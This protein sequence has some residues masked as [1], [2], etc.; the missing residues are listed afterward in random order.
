MTAR[1]GPVRF[2]LVGCGSIAENSLVPALRTVEGGILWAVSSRD[3]EKARGFAS[4]HGA[5][6]TRPAYDS[7]EEMLADPEI[8]AV[9]VATPDGLHASQAIA[10]ARAGKHVFVEKP[11]A[12]NMHDAVAMTEECRRAGVRLGV[13]FQNRW[14]NGHRQ[15]AHRLRG[16]DERIGDVRHMRVEWASPALDA[17]SWRGR[18]DVSRWWCMAALGS[19]CLDLVRWMMVPQCGEV[20]AIRALTSDVAFKSGR[21][22]SAT[23]A[24]RFANGATADIFVSV[25]APRRKYIEIIGDK[26]TAICFD[27]LGKR[28]I[29]AIIVGDDSLDFQPCDPYVGE[30]N[31]FVA[32]IREGRDP[33]VS[34]EEGVRNVALLCVAEDD[35]RRRS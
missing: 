5:R 28:G 29:G 2:G 33:E 31:D 15:L 22:E 14:H 17:A 10:A 23:I 13:A 20:T 32:S 6:S 27:T 24:L 26:A 7:Y 18:G 35:S 3:L 21:D 11:A 30:L 34:G 25:F 12:T 16:G 19:H 9:I 1:P 4:R 8:D